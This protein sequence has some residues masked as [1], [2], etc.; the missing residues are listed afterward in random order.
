MSTPYVTVLLL[1]GLQIILSSL[2]NNSL[3]WVLFYSW[4]R[5]RILS[6]RKYHLQN[7]A[8]TQAVWCDP[9]RGRTRLLTIVAYL[10]SP[11]A[12]LVPHKL[13]LYGSWSIKYTKWAD[14]WQVSRYFPGWQWVKTFQAEVIK[15][16]KQVKIDNCFI[17]LM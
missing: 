10:V 13:F 9:F 14:S 8:Q 17:P 6:N 16:S 5:L 11:R 4:F 15:E 2:Q 12:L 3:K 1:N 7:L